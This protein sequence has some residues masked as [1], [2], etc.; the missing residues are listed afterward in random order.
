MTRSNENYYYSHF[1]DKLSFEGWITHPGFY[2]W[3]LT[4]KSRLT[5]NFSAYSILRHHNKSQ[6]LP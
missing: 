6:E 1:V 5:Y 3:S 2:K 4:E